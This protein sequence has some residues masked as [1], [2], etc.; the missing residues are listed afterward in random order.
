MQTVTVTKGVHWVAIPEAGLSIL[1]GCPADSVKLLMKMGLIVGTRKNGVS[2]ETGPNA[3]LLSDVP[4]QNETFANLSEFPVLQMLYRQGMMVPGHP[5]NTGQKPLLIGLES[6]VRSQSQYIFRGNYGLTSLEEIR[7]A[8]VDDAAARDY[9]R[10]KLWFAFGR[11]RETD[12]MLETR[13]VGASAVALRG[14]AAV[15]RTGF[16]VYEFSCR[17]ETAVVDLNLRQGEHYSSSYSLGFHKIRREY[18]SVVHLGEGDGWDT[19]KPCMGSLVTFQG[20]IYLIDAGP[21]IEQSLTAV[22][23]SVNEIEGIFHSHSHDD[24]FAG[25]TTLVRSDHRIKYYATPLV[26]ASVAKKL[27][28]LMGMD[29]AMFQRYFEVHDLRPAEW[30]DVEG[31]QVKPEISAH[32]VETNVFQFRALWEGGYRTYAHLADVTT[33]EVLRKMA[34]A[35]PDAPGVSRAFA[36]RLEK[37]LL[38]PA[39]LKKLDAGGAPI[40]GAAGDF[41]NDASGRLILSHVSGDLTD[42]QKEIGSNA[43]FGRED[44]LIPANVDYVAQSA[45]RYLRAYFPEV[46]AHSVRMLANCPVLTF[47]AGSIILKKGEQAAAVHLVLQGVGEAIDTQRGIHRTLSGGAIIGELSV[48]MESGAFWTVRA[49]SYITAIMI[50]AQLYLS[51]IRQN[52]LE[53]STRH[54]LDNRLFLQGTWL[55]GELI[56]FSVERAISAAMEPLHVRAGARVEARPSSCLFVLHRGEVELLRDGRPCERLLSGGFWGEEEVLGGA[57][58]FEARAVGDAEIFVIPA[59]LI[60]DIPIVQWRLL[61]TSET[62]SHSTAAPKAA[63]AR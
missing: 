48:L 36:E 6:Q 46:A 41:R 39:D 7:A 53:E 1:C 45:F 5:G 26:R 21:N 31:L 35:A 47:N 23:I 33:F 37:E 12:E 24:H 38:A 27:S 19:E 4:T 20:R 15:R 43:V 11:I 10:M 8:G 56:G 30:N 29:E 40:H 52:S 59:R 62:R 44:V 32:P 55:F 49:S 28:A 2:F 57:R 51:F 58:I 63:R 14:G 3:I 60:A 42:A 9:M 25:L 54:L 16:N 22:G 34:A 13:F 61:Q 17:G 50:P 18:F